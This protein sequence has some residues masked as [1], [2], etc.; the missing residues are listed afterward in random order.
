MVKPAAAAKAAITGT[1]AST[2]PRSAV[3]PNSDE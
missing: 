3:A 1:G 2:A